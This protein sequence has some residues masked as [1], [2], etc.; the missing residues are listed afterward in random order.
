[1]ASQTFQDVEVWQNAHRWVLKVYEYS[2]RFPKHELYGLASQLRRAAVSVPAN[3]AE[4]FKKLGLN[5][6][7]RFYNIAQGSLEE[8]RYYLILA[9]DLGYGDTTEL[10]E[11]LDRVGRLLDG[12]MRVIRNRR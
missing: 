9:A 8:C 11:D 4:G 2:E 12:Y 1:M 3:F 6:K 7:L 5:D 10:K